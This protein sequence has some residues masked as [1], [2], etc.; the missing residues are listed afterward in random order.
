MTTARTQKPTAARI[1]SGLSFC[2]GERV[3]LAVH[4]AE[5]AGTPLYIPAG[6]LRS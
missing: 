2:P 5:F 1:P 4:R 3:S 6:E